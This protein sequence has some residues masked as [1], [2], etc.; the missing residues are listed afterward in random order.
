MI[1][2]TI[3]NAGA[4]SVTF[5]LPASVAAT[6]AVICGEFNDWSPAAHP[7]RRGGDGRLQATVELPAGRAWRFRYLL[8]GER[9]EIDW[10]PD[11]KVRTAI[12]ARLQSP[13]SPL[14]FLWPRAGM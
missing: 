10:A 13:L 14:A 5:E 2:H 7:L 9:W 4:V 1:K 6:T 11:P 3:S 12:A 8:D